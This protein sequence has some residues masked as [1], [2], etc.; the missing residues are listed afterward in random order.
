MRNLRSE[1]GI[2]GD[3]EGIVV[4]VIIVVRLYKKY[5]RLN[6]LRRGKF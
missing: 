5:T 2:L 4:P 3:N 6:D 1:L